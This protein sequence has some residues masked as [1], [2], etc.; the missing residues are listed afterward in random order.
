MK[1][2]LLAIFFLEKV[3]LVKY[4]SACIYF[5]G[6][7][8]T[9]DELMEVLTLIQTNK[10]NQ[11]PIILYDS[12]FWEPLLLWIEQSVKK[13]YINQKHFELLTVVDSIEDIVSVVEKKICL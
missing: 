4:S 11:V 2:L 12:S 13:A 1:R 3:M 10:M 5:P 8:G 9:A 6:G 7:Y